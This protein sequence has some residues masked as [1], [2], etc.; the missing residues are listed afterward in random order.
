MRKRFGTF[1]MIFVLTGIASSLCGQPRSGLH[2][3]PMPKNLVQLEGTLPI[4]SSFRVSLSG[5]KDSHIGAA[6]VRMLQCLGKKTGIPLSGYAFLDSGPATLE[7]HCDKAGEST[8]SLDADESYTLEVTGEGARLAAP[9]SLG[10]LRGLETLLQLVDLDNRSFFMPAVR[11]ED[12]PRF[13]W[14]GLHI[15]VSRHWEPADVI[16]R[17]LDAMAAVKMNVFHWHLSDD[18]GF[19]IESRAFPKLHQYA[20]EGNYYTQAEV[21]DIIA[22]A[23]D[24]GI[25][26]I[27]EFDMPGHATAILVAYPELA[28]AP[29]PYLIERLW[30]VFAPTMDPTSKKLYAFLDSFIGEMAKIFPDEYFHI[31]GDEVSGK[32]WN[33]N[34]KIQAFKTQH[35]LKD[36]AALQAYFNQRLQKILARHGKKM[37]GWDEVF[38]PDLPKSVLLQSWR[39]HSH[40]AKGA[41]QG[42]AGVLSHGYYLDAMRPASFHYANDPLDKEA[43][44]LSDDEKTRILGG[45]ACMWAEFVNSENIESRI[46]PRTAAIAERLWSPQDIRDTQDMYRR[47]ERVSRD[48]EF[49]G[50]MH[51]AHQTQMLQRMTAH[52]DTVSL[53]MF[54]DLL[55]P[56][57]LS[58]RRR[59]QKYSSLSPLNRMVDAVQPESDSAR[60][61]ADQVNNALANP[62]GA[63]DSFQPVRKQLSA[64]RDNAQAL[65]PTLEHSYL[66]REIIPVSEIVA[67][68]CTKGL[69]A[70]NS[71]ETGQKPAET[72]GKESASLLEGAEKPQAEMMIAITAP[73]KTLI[74]AA[75]ALP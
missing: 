48:L 72:W 53:Q 6:V 4:D 38:H 28:S 30:G 22:H 1:A 43:A 61:F 37:I 5:H 39:G 64:W 45:E 35:G 10:I 32:Q 55:T 67:N 73:I 46:W 50:L 27:P 26:V 33:A 17:N 65:R 40:M 19:R 36:N 20:S 51:R 74:E 21:R 52:E 66:L 75:N 70:L 47:L 71:I 8:P 63:P 2:L 25:R 14:R 57:S 49:F 13:R 16:K 9:S 42:Y 23:R 62:S 41:S 18:Q 31:G 56:T 3:M 29:G 15:D 59:I 24:R 69:E 34:P 7:V 60:R 12:A 54:A 58:V 44:A 11:I 68:L